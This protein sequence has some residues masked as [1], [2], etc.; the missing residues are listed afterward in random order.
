MNAITVFVIVL[1]RL[2]LDSN[3]HS[4]QWL[5]ENERVHHNSES[6]I[7]LKVASTEALVI[8]VL[9]FTPGLDKESLGNKNIAS[10]LYKKPASLSV[11]C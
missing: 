7:V 3:L 11:G 4:L 1:Y 10:S 2:L 8:V 6:Q 9:S 5:S